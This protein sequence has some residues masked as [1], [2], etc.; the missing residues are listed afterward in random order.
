MTIQV[1]DEKLE[2]RIKF[3]PFVSVIT[4]H[5]GI[6]DEKVVLSEYIATQ[7]NYSTNNEVLEGKLVFRIYIKDIDEEDNDFENIYIERS[8]ENMKLYSRN[9]SK[10]DLHH[11]ILKYAKIFNLDYNKEKDSDEEYLSETLFTDLA[12]L[13]SNSV[14]YYYDKHRQENHHGLSHNRDYAFN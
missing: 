10:G 7:L 4:R 9:D 14:L 1:N 6:W 13:L 3:P 5:T 2:E 12:E 8:K 11:L